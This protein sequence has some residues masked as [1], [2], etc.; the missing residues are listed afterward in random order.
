MTAHE[1][2]GRPTPATDIDYN[3]VDQN[4]FGETDEW[5]LKE[6]TPKEADAAIRLMRALLAWIFQNGMKNTDGITLRAILICWIF[7][8]E[9]RPLQLSELARGF[10]KDKQSLGRWHDQFKVDFPFI[11]TPH[12]RQ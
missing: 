1:D 9:L 5:D 7:L 11:K 8:K 12:M 2:D 3:A 6:I 4:L 10:G